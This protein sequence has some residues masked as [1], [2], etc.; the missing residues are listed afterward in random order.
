[1]RGAAIPAWLLDWLIAF[2]FTEAV[3]IPIYVAALPCSFL[4]AFG[5]SAVTH[6]IVWFGFFGLW[7]RA[8]YLVKV[9][10]AE[11]FAVL[12][13]A[14]YFKLLFRRRRALLWSAVANAASLGLGLLSRHLFG[15][16]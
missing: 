11:A 12:A 16:P 1:V 5:A 10:V 8:G 2:L 14:A 9:F 7:W 15:V 3:E 13:E 6:P 4:V